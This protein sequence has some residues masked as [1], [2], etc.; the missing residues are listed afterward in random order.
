[1]T[2]AIDRTHVMSIVNLWDADARADVVERTPHS[3]EL[4]LLKSAFAVGGE[5]ASNS[6]YTVR[7]VGPSGF[8]ADFTPMA[9]HGLVIYFTPR[10][11]AVA[12]A[13]LPGSPAP[14]GHVDL[15]AG[16]ITCAGQDPAILGW[17]LDD[18]GIA[19]VSVVVERGDASDDVVEMGNAQRQPRPDVAKTFPSLPDSANAGWAFSF[20][21]ASAKAKGITAPAQVVVIAENTRG[22]RTRL[23]T[24]ALQ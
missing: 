20:P 3:F 18:E 21:C 10:T 11:T 19:R 6:L 4:Q 5:P 15:P 12:A 13:T 9:V 8:I 1:L 23:G 16:A 17:A 7:D 2:E 14:F 24:R 22:G